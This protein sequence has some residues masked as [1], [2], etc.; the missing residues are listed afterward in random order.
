MSTGLERRAA[1]ARQ[2]PKLRLTSLAHHIDAERLWHNLC[3][4]PRQTAPG[5][6]GQTVAEV[7]QDFGAWSEATLRAVHTQGYRPPPVRRTYIPKPGKREQRPLGVPCVGD[8]VL[9]RRGADV[10]SALDEPD[11]LPGSFGGR[12][13]V[14]APHALATRHEVLAGKPVRGVYEADRRDFFG[15]LDQGW[16]RRL[17]HHRVGDPRLL[18]LIRRWLKAGGLEDGGMEPSEEGGPHG[19]S[20]SVV[21]SHLSLHDVLD[22]WCDRSVK[23]RLHGEAYLMRYMDD[24]VVC[25]QHRADAERF[26]QVVVKRLAKFA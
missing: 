20:S 13:G 8:R 18:R 25:F 2:E 11:F 5:S 24:V 19:G 15:S 6:D 12:P 26:Q 22:R 9:Q 14:G 7:K 23:P 16:C 1:K 4:V 3:H 10:L 17:V 21:L